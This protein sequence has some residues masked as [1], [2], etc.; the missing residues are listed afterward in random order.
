MQQ[1]QTQQGGA[2]GQGSAPREI[3]EQAPVPDELN[4]D[5]IMALDEP[6]LIDI[7]NDSS[8]TLFQKAMACKKLATVGT[9]ASIEPLAALLDEERLHH[10]ARFGLEPN[11]DPAVDAVFR[12]ALG[13]LSGQHLIG[14]ITSVGTRQDA[15]AVGALSELVYDSNDAVAQA[16]VAAL[17]MIGGSEPARVLREAVSAADTT[18][19]RDA[20]AWIASPAASTTSPSPTE[21][22][23][24]S[25]TRT[26]AGS[27]SPAAPSAA[28]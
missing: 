16:A 21:R 25:I 3:R 18:S 5:P 27:T 9:A 4:A 19:S 15:R 6:A 22:W 23:W 28:W 1:A 14:V 24:A 7:L 26:R 13:T 2:R 20:S 12:E 11:P 17:G 10:Y 8:S